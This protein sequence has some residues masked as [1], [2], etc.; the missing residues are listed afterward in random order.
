MATRARKDDEDPDDLP[1]HEAPRARDDGGVTVDLSELPSDEGGKK[2]EGEER[3]T[4]KGGEERDLVT[5]DEGALDRLGEQES[6]EVRTRRREERKQ[7]KEQRKARETELE[8]RLETTENELRAVREQQARGA[9]DGVRTEIERIE[10]EMTSLQRTYNDAKALK[11]RAYN[12]QKGKEAVE[13]DEAMAAARESYRQLGFRREQI[14]TSVEESRARPQVS[15]Q[16]AT[17]ARVFMKDHD[18]YDIKGGDR[19]SAQVLKIDRA[20][21]K[22][23]WDPNTAGYW[24][25]LRE[26]VQEELPHRFGEERD[27][28]RRNGRERVAEEEERRPAPRRQITGGS[29]RDAGA[30]G[31]KNTFYLNRERV[32]ALK[33]AGMWEDPVKRAK[34]IRT[35]KARDEKEAREKA[36][37]R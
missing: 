19:D 9:A 17:H 20:M 27:P 8:S 28:P 14:L 16:L 26:R 4:R 15:Q 23:G 35:Y 21:A 25:E 36:Q 18:W 33:E 29:D 3:Q 13:A 24:E 7:R 30:S 37:R 1:D 31:G 12:E 10:G 34:M 6:E 5:D 2:K 32:A 22:E 11:E